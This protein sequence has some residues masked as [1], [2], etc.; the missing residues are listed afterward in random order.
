MVEHYDP[1]RLKFIANW[2]ERLPAS[3]TEFALNAFPR[4]G[5]MDDGRGA[6]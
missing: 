1:V 6:G 4:Q 3:E 2:R 5:V